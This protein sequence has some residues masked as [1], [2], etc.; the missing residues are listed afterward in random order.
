MAALGKTPRDFG[1]RVRSHP[2]GLVITAANK[3]KTGTTM[4]VSYAGAVTETIQF[5]RSTIASNLSL[6]ERFV[7]DLGR[8]ENADVSPL[9]WR[10]VDVDVVQT[11]LRQYLTHPGA[12]KARAPLLAKYIDAQ[13]AVGELTKWT[14]ALVSKKP[15]PGDG[16]KTLS[17]VFGGFD[18]G[19]TD[20]APTSEPGAQTITIKRLLAPTHELIDLD[21]AV[22]KKALEETIKR[23]KDPTRNSRYKNKETAPTSP[24]GAVLREM[25]APQRGLFLLYPLIPDGLGPPIVGFGISFPAS[26]KAQSVE[27]VVNNTY[28]EQLG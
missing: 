25:R 20:R 26:D 5:E 19:L 13:V 14:V 16:T 27:Y 2:D 10:D 22:V 11:F 3:M 1:L 6:T 24:S 18:V 9:V 8:P 28:W 17:H 7:R 12:T 23:W 15:E 21:E 4:T